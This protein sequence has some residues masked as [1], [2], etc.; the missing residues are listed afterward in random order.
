MSVTGRRGFLALVGCVFLAWKSPGERRWRRMG[1]R[2]H[3]PV[4][5]T[6]SNPMYNISTRGRLIITG[7]LCIRMIPK[8]AAPMTVPLY[9]RGTA[10]FFVFPSSSN[11]NQRWSSD[12]RAG[13]RV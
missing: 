1:P 7:V 9:N 2:V 4:L 13:L 3:A 6:L 8:M 11:I 10:V 5:A 12:A